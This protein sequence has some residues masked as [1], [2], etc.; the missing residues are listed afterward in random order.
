MV[1]RPFSM[2]VYV[3]FRM[4]SRAVRF[5]VLLLC[6]SSLLVHE[7]RAQRIDV[8]AQEYHLTFV[9]Y[10]VENLF[11]TIPS[12]LYS[13]QDFTP[14]GAYRWTSRRYWRK[15][16]KLSQVIMAVDT[17]HPADIIALEEIESDTVMRDLLEHT[18]LRA[19]GYRY[20][21][22]NSP[23][24]RGVNIALVYNPLQYRLMG[25]DTLRLVDQ[26]VR[27][28]DVLHTWGTL[29]MG[30]TLHVYAVHLPSQLGGSKAR[31]VRKRLLAQMA[32]HVRQALAS[33]TRTH[34]VIMGDFNASPYSADIRNFLKDLPGFVNLS[35]GRP[36]G[37]YRYRGRW[38]WIDQVIVSPSLVRPE[39]GAHVCPPLSQALMH[40]YLLQPD[41]A[42]GGF[43]PRR[44][45]L[46]HFYEGGTSDHLP[47]FI[48]V[49]Y[50]L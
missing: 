33:T 22:T 13:D 25:K 47:V 17:V 28:R 24:A 39:G 44:T 21:K 45:F 18:P 32:Q 49:A 36:L 30:D 27:T 11:D 31:K 12:G 10:N 46:G 37:S 43:K 50:A 38:D 29:P 40:P 1:D 3:I 7:V 16:R 15:L 2:P 48:R 19:L 23:D 6:L 9:A 26:T 41:K 42:Y 14:A 34:A 4:H 5:I 20:V 35:D 8:R